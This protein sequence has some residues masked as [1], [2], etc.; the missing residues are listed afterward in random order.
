MSGKYPVS[1][2]E[3][4]LSVHR[5]TGPSRRKY[6]AP[7]DDTRSS[8]KYCDKSDTASAKPLLKHFHVNRAVKIP[9]LIYE[10][11]KTAI[12][13]SPH[14]LEC[15]EEVRS[16]AFKKEAIPRRVSH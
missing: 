2:F 14:D 12:R 1:F 10:S 15:E 6:A 16:S 3:I 9:P 11:P 8:S 13:T 4:P 5:M 7:V